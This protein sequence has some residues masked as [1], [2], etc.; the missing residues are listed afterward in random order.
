MDMDVHS[1]GESSVTS[2]ERQGH[3]MTHMLL[4]LKRSEVKSGQQLSTQTSQ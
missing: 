1:D 3:Y 2:L 4:L